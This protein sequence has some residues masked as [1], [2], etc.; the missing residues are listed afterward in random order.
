MHDLHDFERGG[1]ARVLGKGE[2]LVDIP[3]RGSFQLPKD[4][5]DFQFGFC[6]FGLHS[7]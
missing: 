4:G 3:H 7:G 5:E 6:W 2:A 1:V